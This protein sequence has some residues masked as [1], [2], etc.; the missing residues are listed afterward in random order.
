[1]ARQKNGDRLSGI[2]GQF[3]ARS[4][5]DVTGTGV[6]DLP[7]PAMRHEDGVQTDPFLEAP[8]GG[9]PPGLGDIG[10]RHGGE[11]PSIPHGAT[12]PVGAALSA[13]HAGIENAGKRRGAAAQQ[14]APAHSYEPPASAVETQLLADLT[15]TRSKTSR[16]DA[17][18]ITFA[19]AQQ[20]AWAR[21]KRKKFLGLF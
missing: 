11:A 7:R 17:D 2:W 13:M 16:R 15:F 10:R 9:M 8:L 5:L 14:S 6:E 20:E 21:R 19:A 1:M 12:D 3:A 4:S 18:Y